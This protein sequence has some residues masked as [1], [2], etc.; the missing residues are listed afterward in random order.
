MPKGFQEGGLSFAFSMLLL[1]YALFGFGAMRLLESWRLCH[2]SYSTLMGKAY[3]KK[4][5]MLVRLT[6]VAQQCGI[7]L[8]YF[9]FVAT[10]AKELVE[11]AM[12]SVTAPSLAWL[13]LVQVAV[14]APLS[15][16]RNVQ[17]FAYF[18]LLANALILYA[19]LVLTVFASF[20]VA[21]RG[22]AHTLDH[23]KLFNPTSFY[24]FIGTSAFVYEGSAALVVPLQEAV[25]DDLQ[26]QFAPLYLKTM[27]LIVF[28]YIAFGCI[29]WAAYGT[30][31]ET[32]LTVNLPDGV[33]KAS[34]QLAYLL[35]VIFT[36]PLQLFPAVQI[37]KSVVHK[38]HSIRRKASLFRTVSVA[39][40]GNQ[41]AEYEPV[42]VHHD[43]TTDN[44]VKANHPTRRLEGN[45]ARGV[46]VFALAGISVLEVHSLDKLVALIGGLLGIPLA[47]VYPL[48]IHLRLVPDAP[49]TTRI[50]DFVC[51]VVGLALG[52]ACTIVSVGVSLTRMALSRRSLSLL[53]SQQ[54]LDMSRLTSLV[55]SNRAAV[56]LCSI[57]DSILLHL[58][59]VTAYLI[60][61]TAPSDNSTFCR[62]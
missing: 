6:I 3:G 10:N 62:Q 56:W 36:F 31:T 35:A 45:V 61:I 29:N 41:R 19:L 28:V 4:G 55:V 17:N 25:R 2:K 40:A 46:L 50:L 33:W 37:L 52:L 16:V 34:V 5:T 43:S 26:A 39:T 32:V 8:T 38:L 11:F 7:C 9:V 15:C 24:L 57:S 14:Y 53:G 22:A 30:S 23:L 60:K 54:R 18:N 48:V 49:R 12:P 59:S 51:I 1:S 58:F 44:I 27:M 47:F 42:P 20:R 21:R 13:C